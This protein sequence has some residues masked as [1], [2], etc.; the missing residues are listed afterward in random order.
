MSIVAMSSTETMPVSFRSD[1]EK[2]HFIQYLEKFEV[3]NGLP[4]WDLIAI[5]Q[6]YEAAL[7]ENQKLQ[8]RLA[9]AITYTSVALSTLE[10]K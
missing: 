9:R 10:G 4:A 7:K 1:A 3:D 2:L 8:E 6:A 5:F